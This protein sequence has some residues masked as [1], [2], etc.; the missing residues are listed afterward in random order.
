MTVCEICRDSGMLQ[1]IWRSHTTSNCRAR[2]CTYCKGVGAPPAKFMTH[3][4]VHCREK[5]RGWRAPSPRRS[6]DQHFATDSPPRTSWKAS[7]GEKTVRVCGFFMNGAH[8][9]ILTQSRFG[10][11]A[12]RLS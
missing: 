2:V 6:P 8:Q 3:S 10:E 1:R 12:R 7:Q 11:K 4:S 9:L 5:P